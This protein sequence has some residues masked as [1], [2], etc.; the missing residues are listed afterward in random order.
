MRGGNMLGVGLIYGLVAA[1]ISVVAVA[2]FSAARSKR[3]SRLGLFVAGL[4]Y[5]IA[6]GLCVADTLIGNGVLML[7][8]LALS[9]LAFFALAVGFLTS[10]E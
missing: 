6:A 2:C 5:F 7:I 4:L 3:G 10:S 8:A 9:F 1:A